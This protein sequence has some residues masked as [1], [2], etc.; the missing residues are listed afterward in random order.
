M[1]HEA[2]HK[3]VALIGRPNVGKSTLFNRIL[4]EQRAIVHDIS[5]VTRD[6]H[7]ADAE[8]AG[9][10]FTLIDTGGFI[11]KSNDL[12][13]RAI[14]EQTAMAIEEADAVVLLVDAQTGPTPLDFEIAEV[15]RKYDKKVLLAANKVDGP[16]AEVT[17]AEFYRLGLGSP[18]PVSA[19]T[20]RNVGDFLDR[21]VKDFHTNGVEE[22]TESRI[23]VAIIGRPNV[24]KSSL[25]NA[26]LGK[27]RSIVTEIP[28][29]T[30]DSI[31]SV[32]RHAGQEFLLIDTAGVRKRHAVK[33]S[34]EF[35][36]TIRTLRSIGRCDVAV[37]LIDATQGLGKQDLRIVSLV[38]E[39]K[40]GI[41]IAVNKWD[42]V[43]KN[44]RTALEFERTIKRRLRMYSYAPILFVSAKTKQRIYQILE[45]SKQVSDQ[46]MR[47][48]ET[49]AL[50]KVLLR[51]IELFPPSS[52]SGKEIKIKYVTQVK[53]APPVFAFF[54]NNP[55]LVSTDYIRFI[56]NRIR[57]HFGFI[58][59]PI[60][61][62]FKK[63]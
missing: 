23:K 41:V 7:Y 22:E 60:S 2:G 8:W 19:L 44:E 29:T 13:E 5:G 46:R 58:G 51:E 63:K 30:R 21:L 3:V 25:A 53:S 45:L 28:G 34:I 17:T 18:Y 61:I 52:A 40:K 36:G 4:G 26:L 33:E 16:K 54:A 24:G 10:R 57:Q 56:E 39:R 15:I 43:E 27:P 6:R 38:A 1:S 62:V 31:D 48:I 9:K 55:T 37:V 42:L 11:P 50:N 59:V 20:G 47:T 49:S 12:I 35:F 14:R 32:L